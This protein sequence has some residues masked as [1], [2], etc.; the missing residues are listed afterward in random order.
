MC[1]T[2]KK[3][4][5]GRISTR[6]TRLPHPP[7]PLPSPPLPFLFSSPFFLTQ[8]SIVSCSTEINLC[9]GIFRIH[10]TPG[11]N[12][13]VKRQ[14]Y[15]F[16][17]VCSCVLGSGAGFFISISLICTLSSAHISRSSWMLWHSWLF[18]LCFY[19]INT[20][21]KGPKMAAGLICI[22]YVNWA[23]VKNS[24]SRRVVG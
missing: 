11:L 14:S 13:R 10:S 24:N 4:K 5:F 20:E 18:F 23:H 9:L 8:L 22:K 15:L 1:R 21:I 19:E 12:V 16:S 17:D 7:P 6:N 2:L 3:R